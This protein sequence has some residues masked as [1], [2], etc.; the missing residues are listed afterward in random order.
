VNSTF[1]TYLRLFLECTSVRLHLSRLVSGTHTVSV[2]PNV[3]ARRE[4]SAEKLT[5]PAGRLRKKPTLSHLQ[6]ITPFSATNNT[7]VE[8]AK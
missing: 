5:S 8:K 1:I 2:G 6:T 3:T 4:P 7:Q